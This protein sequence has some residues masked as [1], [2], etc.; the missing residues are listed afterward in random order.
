M[1]KEELTVNKD[2]N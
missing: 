2:F 1:D